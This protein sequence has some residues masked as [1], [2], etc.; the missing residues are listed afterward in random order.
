MRMFRV[1]VLV[2]FVSL[3]SAAEPEEFKTLAGERTGYWWRSLSRLEKVAFG[4]T[5]VHVYRSEVVLDEG[6]GKVV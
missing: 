4:S 3:C 6:T 5:P 2:M 1:V